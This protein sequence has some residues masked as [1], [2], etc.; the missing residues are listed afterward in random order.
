MNLLVV[1][2]MN[3][4]NEITIWFIESTWCTT[5]CAMHL[6]ICNC[7]SELGK[8]TTSFSL[9][10]FILFCCL[11]TLLPL[12]TE[13]YVLPSR[14]CF[15]PHSHIYSFSGF[16]NPF[17]DKTFNL[18]LVCFLLLCLTFQELLLTYLQKLSSF[19]SPW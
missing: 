7:I 18:P 15:F 2:D 4:T 13:Y 11:G 5:V 3:C 10:I 8:E 19:V 12:I 14:T 1:G 16:S 6:F 17:T 9:M